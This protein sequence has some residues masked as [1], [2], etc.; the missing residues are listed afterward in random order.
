MSKLK[1]SGISVSLSFWIDMNCSWLYFLFLLNVIAFKDVDGSLCNIVTYI[2]VLPDDSDGK[3][4]ARAWGFISRSG[5]TP[6]E[7]ND[8]PLQYSCLE[9]SRDRGAWLATL[10]GIAKSQIL[11]SE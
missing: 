9:N 2:T 1:V 8:N 10:Y 6:G 7:E 11:L 5:R 3:E 4:Y